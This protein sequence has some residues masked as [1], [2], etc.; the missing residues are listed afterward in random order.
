MVLQNHYHAACLLD[1]YK[2]F[3]IQ[4]DEKQ[5]LIDKLSASTYYLSIIFCYLNSRQRAAC[6]CMRAYTHIYVRPYLLR[7]FQRN[8]SVDESRDSFL[9][10]RRLRLSGK[11]VA[12]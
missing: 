8:R 10:S 11:S 6:V 2:R 3:I 7:N 12:D 4:L 5:D 9:P 1:C